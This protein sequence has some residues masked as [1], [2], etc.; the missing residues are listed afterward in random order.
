MAVFFNLRLG[1]TLSALVVPGYLVPLMIARPTTVVVIL[2]ESVITYYISTWISEANRGHKYWSSLF[3]RDR[4]FLI[5]VVSILVRSTMDGWLLPMLG[6]YLVQQGYFTLDVRSDLNSFGLIVVALI[7]NYFWKPG[8]ARGIMPLSILVA[9]TW[10]VVQCVFVPLTNFNI[11]NFHLLYEDVSVSM[12]A[13]PKSYMVLVATAW[14]AS[15]INLRYAWDFSGILIP[16]LLSL[17]WVSPERILF[18]LLEAWLVFLIGSRLCNTSFFRSRSIQGGRKLAFFFTICFVLRFVMAHAMASW[19]P[20]WKATDFFGMGYLLSTLMAIKIHDR[21]APLRMTKGIVQVSVLG[22]VAGCLLGYLLGF[23]VSASNEHRPGATIA[24]NGSA[25]TASG[26]DLLTLL[27]EEKV[28]LYRHRSSGHTETPSRA[29]VAKF[30][31]AIQVANRLE[32]SFSDPLNQK[33]LGWI[34]KTLAEINFELV[35]INDKHLLV[36]EM[37]PFRGWGWFVISPGS[38]KKLAISVESPLEERW[39]GESAVYLLDALDAR[40]LAVAATPIIK[41]GEKQQSNRLCE[42]FAQSIEKTE[43]LAIRGTSSSFGSQ[44]ANADSNTLA[45]DGGVLKELGLPQLESLTGVFRVRWNKLTAE[46]LQRSRL[47]NV[48]PRTCTLYLTEDS[49]RNLAA[50]SVMANSE[51]SGQ[52]VEQINERSILKVPVSAWLKEVQSAIC[53]QGSDEYVT[54]REEE[55][56]FIDEEIL[57]PL[58]ELVDGLPQQRPSVADF[59]RITALNHAA[60]SVGY[61]L[62]VIHDADSDDWFMGLREKSSEVASFGKPVNRL[63]WGTV[64]F[65]FGMKHDMCVEVPRPLFERKSFE[66]GSSL[67][68]FPGA[69]ALL[70]AGS[71]PRANRDGSSDMTRSFNRGN[72]LNLSRHVLLRELGSRPF[73]VVQ[74]RSIQAPVKSDIVVA[75]DNGAVSRRALSR[76]QKSLVDW[77]DADGLSVEF[78]DGRADVAGYELG[79]LIR[80]TTNQVSENKEV[81]SLWLSPGLRAAYRQQQ[82]FDN[83]NA[84]L[85]AC[86]LAQITGGRPSLWHFEQTKFIGEP[87]SAEL[88]KSLLQYALNHD[89]VQMLTMV[90]TFDQFQF[91]RFF[92]ELSGTTLIVIRNSEQ[93]IVGIFNPRGLEGPTLSVSQVTESEFGQ[94]ISSRGVLMEVNDVQIP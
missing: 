18:S 85:R 76:L 47:G 10:F 56:L 82:E 38:Q 42:A 20:E 49:R 40:S 36:R 59:E 11:G 19:V 87:L 50:R 79:V 65:R 54:P 71:H 46:N 62:D 4:F 77:F 55:L 74:T 7:A 9:A 24:S 35:V 94:F 41:R 1:W 69:S 89:A 28:R 66:F 39:S 15:W 60:R 29:T 51:T 88:K 48:G 3:G 78:V 68:R 53:Q 58:V 90:R 6:D 17:L 73:L 72:L 70:I 16:A 93:Q 21:E 75:T 23:F 25:I 61:S 12:L 63:G 92:D 30:S 83:L 45:I 26:Q 13:S 27:R 14:I 80:A 64:L 44:A 8:F 37:E 91:L 52:T 81:I 57:E 34:G 31:D 43:R 67:F 32:G 5:V 22:A 86:G 33:T 84:Q 2:F